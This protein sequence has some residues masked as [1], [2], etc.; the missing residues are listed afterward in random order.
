MVTIGIYI[1]QS[2]I[3]NNK[4]T[5]NQSN[6]YT[7]IESI[8]YSLQRVAQVLLDRSDA[9]RMPKTEFN[10]NQEALGYPTS[11]KQ[12]SNA[13]LSEDK[14]RRINVSDIPPVPS[15]LGEKENKLQ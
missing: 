5:S 13:G 4:V 12:V 15:E 8:R 9:P 10:Y 3:I 2:M 11:T 7:V 6:E 14:P 1:I